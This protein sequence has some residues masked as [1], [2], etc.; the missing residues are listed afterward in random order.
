MDYNP[1]LLTDPQ[2]IDIDAFAQNYLGAHQSYEYLSHCGVYLGMT[3]FNDTNRVEIYDPVMQVADYTSAKANTIIIDR[4]LLEDDQDQRYRYTV[5]HECG[6]I[7]LGHQAYFG[8]DPNQITLDQLYGT[9]SPAIVR[10]RMNNARGRSQDTRSWSDEDWMEWQ[11]DNFSSC[12]LLPRKAI[13]RLSNM[14]D[15][16]YDYPG[17]HGLPSLIDAVPKVFNVS[18]EAAMIRLRQLGYVNNHFS[19]KPES[20]SYVEF[21]TFASLGI[22]V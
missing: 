11:A 12:L 5:G 7:G 16:G 21:Y 4:S 20:R 22:C 15:N 10:C 3:V 13:V 9:G 1:K 8:Y 19:P 6:H 14:I 2:E 17:S 18:H